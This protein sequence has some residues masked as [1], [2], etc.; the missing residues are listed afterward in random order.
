MNG[1]HSSQH[2]G[3]VRGLSL[4]ARIHAGFAL[5]TVLGTVC[6]LLAIDFGGWIVAL[7]LVALAALTV[8]GNQAMAKKGEVDPGQTTEV[9]LQDPK[10]GVNF[11]P[12][13]FQYVDKGPNRKERN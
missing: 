4:R 6:G 1:D 5:V 11:P 2:R 9:A 13:T 7:G 12:A 3:G 10:F 8:A